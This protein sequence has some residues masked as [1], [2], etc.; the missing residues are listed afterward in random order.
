MILRPLVFPVK[1]F[2]GVFK[3][4]SSELR[5]S[6][7]RLHHPLFRHRLRGPRRVRHAQ[8]LGHPGVNV[9]KLFSFVSDDE[10]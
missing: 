5:D 1:C 10:A 8:L 2:I 7:G 4:T 6:V 9:T 3:Q